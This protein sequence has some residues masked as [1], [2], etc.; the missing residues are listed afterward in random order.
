MFMW[1]ILLFALGIAAFFDSI[2]NL[3]DIF[4]QV[5]SVIFLLTAVGLLVRTTTQIKRGRIENFQSRVEKLERD[6][7]SLINQK[8]PLDF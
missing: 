6:I 7:K 8:Q 3:G 4:R 5:N 2:Y 1:V